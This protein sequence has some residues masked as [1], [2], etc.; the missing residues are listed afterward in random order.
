MAYNSFKP[1]IALE[2]CDMDAL[3]LMNHLLLH[4]GINV[5]SSSA[6]NICGAMQLAKL[7]GPG[8]TLVTI[9]CDSGTRYSNKISNPSYLQSR[10]LPVPS[11]LDDTNEEKLQFRA[12][13]QKR[14]KEAI[15]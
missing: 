5:G 9:L 1:D 11:W 3:P 8:H 4:E 7:L 12:D 14:L 10:S 6:I 15:V 13:L 2:I